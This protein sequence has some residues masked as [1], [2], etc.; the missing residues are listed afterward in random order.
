MNYLYL[1]IQ[2]YYWIQKAVSDSQNFEDGGLVCNGQGN[3]RA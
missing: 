2:R 3:K 1:L